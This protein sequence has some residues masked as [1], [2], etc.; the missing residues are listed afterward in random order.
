[1]SGQKIFDIHCHI[2]PNVD[3]GAAD[4]KETARMLKM[5]YRQGVRNIIVTPHFRP[6]MFETP[7]EK[8]KDQFNHVQQDAHEIGN[9]LS[10]YLGCEFHA[11]MDMIS[12]LRDGKVTTMAGSRYVLME[13]SGSTDASYMRDR[14][15][16][17]LSSGYRPIAAHIER[18]EC[19]RN[20]LDFV[21]E[22]VD[23]GA[24]MQVNAD[25]VIG[26]EGFSAKRFCRK[27]M[28]YGLLHFVGSDCHGST[29]RISRIG[30]AYSQIAR[31]MGEDYAREIFVENPQKILES[32]KQI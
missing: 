25:A 10:V 14:L 18:Y 2:V 9:D 13:F 19:T 28:K 31:K 16:S 21:E 7:L 15:Y 11:N 8:I 24:Y 32:G 17:L 5:E 6:G 27:L 29:G 1:M 4:I 22:L 3:D 30:E 20:D 26:K 23:M 12:M